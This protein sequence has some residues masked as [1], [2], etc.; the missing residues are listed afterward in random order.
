MPSRINDLGIA[1]FH[2]IS[3]RTWPHVGQGELGERLFFLLRLFLAV[4]HEPAPEG[5]PATAGVR[6]ALGIPENV[7]ARRP[8]QPQGLVDGGFQDW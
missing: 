3:H 7:D 1:F 8:L 6:L 2:S 5:V 4:L